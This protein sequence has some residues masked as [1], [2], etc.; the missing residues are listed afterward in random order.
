MAAPF[1][2]G[3]ELMRT[4]PTAIFLLLAAC[5]GQPGTDHAS[6]PVIATGELPPG[7]TAIGRA[8]ARDRC[9]RPQYCGSVGYVDCH[10][11]A[12]G[13]AYYFRRGSGEIISVCGG[14]CMADN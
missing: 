12:D 7:N 11:M 6:A 9:S 4:I 8:A 5:S 14:A 2:P 1:S 3:S 13:P 10:S